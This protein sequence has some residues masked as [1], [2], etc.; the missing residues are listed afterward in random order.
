MAVVEIK[1]K[2][3][4]EL[5]RKVTLSI[6]LSK[7]VIVPISD[8]VTLVSDDYEKDSEGNLCKTKIVTEI[9]EKSV[10]CTA[11]KDYVYN[12]P[13]L[14]LELSNLAKNILKNTESKTERIHLTNIIEGCKNWIE[15]DYQIIDEENE[16]K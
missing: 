5:K 8:Y 12:I 11:V 10:L 13:E 2:Y 16:Y 15:D 6:S 14:L 4:K 3:D 9:V 7:E 1:N